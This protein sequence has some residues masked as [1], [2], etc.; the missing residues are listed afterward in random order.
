MMLTILKGFAV[1]MFL[2]LLTLLLIKM[3]SVKVLVGLYITE[4]FFLLCYFLGLV[5]EDILD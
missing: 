1:I 4:V 3:F 5:V 2:G